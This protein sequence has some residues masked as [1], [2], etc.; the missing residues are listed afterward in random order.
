L[1]YFQ[2]LSIFIHYYPYIYRTF[3]LLNII[4]NKRNGGREQPMWAFIIIDEATALCKFNRK[5][6]EIEGFK[7]YH[8]YTLIKSS[9]Y[10]P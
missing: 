5:Y 2:Q 10:L 1:D 3:L 4:L 6:M 8:K 9:I 7:H